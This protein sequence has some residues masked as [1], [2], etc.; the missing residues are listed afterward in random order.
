MQNRVKKQD[1]V[2]NKF[3]FADNFT[4]CAIWAER[5]IFNAIAIAV[6]TTWAGFFL[7]AVLLVKHIFILVVS[8]IAN[9]YVICLQLE[10]IDVECITD[11]VTIWYPIPLFFTLYFNLLFIYLFFIWLLLLLLRLW[12]V[13]SKYSISVF[14]CA[15]FMN[16]LSHSTQLNTHTHE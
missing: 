10:T 3:L 7:S 13:R 1:S 4:V 5:D 15:L 11:N 8:L 12:F 9:K 6:K 2:R 14:R 16:R